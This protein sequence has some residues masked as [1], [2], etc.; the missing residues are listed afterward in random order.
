MSYGDYPDLK[1]VKKILII[2]L[3]QLGDALLTGPVF[4]SLKNRFPESSIDAYVYS[5]AIPLLE[6]HPAISSFLSYDRNWKKK[7]LPFRLYQEWKLLRAIRSH[8]YDLVINLTEGD[9]GAIAAK[10]SR[11][12][13][14]VGFDPKGK[15]LFGKKKL[16]THV[17][18]NC[19]S[20]RHVVERNLDAIRR[21][22][23]FPTEEERDLFLPL[24]PTALETM[25]KQVGEKF[26]LIHPT[27]RWRFKCWP[28]ENMRAL[29]KHL[30]AE[31]K[32]LVFTSG[33]DQSEQEMVQEITQGLDIYNLAGKISLKDLAALIELSSLLICVDSL[34]LH[35]ASALKKPVLA[36]FGP[37]SEITWGP[38]RNRG[39]RIVA[40]TLPC[41]PCYQ[42]GCG[43]SKKSDCLA[44][45]SVDRVLDALLLMTKEHDNATKRGLRITL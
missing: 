13:I 20:L 41:R 34:P 2:K 31:G 17:A 9:R 28:V 7:S 21:I 45:L 32:R 18:K 5:E 11:A 6:G 40:Q 39:A 29:S 19:P 43:G 4:S 25:K 26:I 3:R 8:R 12:R 27:S 42:D 30:L 1:N 36:I 15:G 33:P 44:T 16:Y 37:T 10:Y 35:M 24:S 38:W 14:R 22:G 23:I